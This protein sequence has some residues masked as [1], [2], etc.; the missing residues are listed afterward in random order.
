MTPRVA[1]LFPAGWLLLPGAGRISNFFLAVLGG[2]A[3]CPDDPAV[4]G[5]PS[6]DRMPQTLTRPRRARRGFDRPARFPLGAVVG[7]GFCLP[8]TLGAAE[9]PRQVFDLPAGEAASA[10]KQFAA[11]SGEQLLYSPGDVAGVTT[12]AVKGEFTS[13]AALERMLERTPL[14]ARQ[15]E[16][17][18]AIAIT[19]GLPSH[20]PPNAASTAPPTLAATPDQT[21]TAQ[22]KPAENPSV[23]PRKLL[24]VLA[25]WLA[26]ATAADAQSVPAAGAKPAAAPE[27]MVKLEAFTVT[28]SNIKRL[29][30]EKVLPVTVFDAAQIEVRDASQ[31]SDLLT[32]LPQVTGLPGNET[33]TLGATARG[34]NATI[35]LRGIA[36]SNALILLNG[37]RLA[38]HPIS[39]SEAGTCPRCRYQ[40]QPAPE[41]RPRTRGAAA[42]R[43]LLALR[44]RRRRRRP[45]LRPPP[46]TFSSGTELSARFGETGYH[47]GQEWRTTL[48]HG[49]RLRPGQGPRDVLRRLLSIAPRSNANQSAPSPP[50]TTTAAIAPA[51]WNIATNTTFNARS[52]TTEYGNYIARHASAATDQYGAVT[53]FAGARPTGVP[54]DARRRRPASSSSS[55]TAPVAQPSAR[56]RPAVLAS[57][58]TITGTTTPTASSSPSLESHERFRQ[59]GIRSHRQDHRVCR[60]EPLPR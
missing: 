55:P 21:T 20:A 27:E 8:A 12:N 16:S 54:G 60:C 52:A 56:R 58:T 7:M 23:K 5:D 13:L 18:N 50:T 51:P 2:P 11:Q 41:S 10:L 37:R 40:C 6:A 4:T 44:H 22:T 47:D 28:G 24:T 34:D 36:S 45:Q 49:L 19:A 57:R 1:P 33:A 30:V 3:V 25:T 59:R 53:G 39:Q 31:P 38:P 43:R 29:E 26:A 46:A 42:R 15:D 35:S 48:T 9:A 32:A 14:R 17:T